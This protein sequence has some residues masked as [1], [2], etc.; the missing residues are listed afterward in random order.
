MTQ[1]M[2]LVVLSNLLVLLFCSHIQVR[3][4]L[5]KAKKCVRGFF[6]VLSVLCSLFSW[7][8]SMYTRTVL[9]NMSSMCC[10]AFGLVCGLQD[11]W[12]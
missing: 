8:L 9:T 5:E 3:N 12:W 10:A 11:A 7:Q 4:G 2:R 6:C 1:K